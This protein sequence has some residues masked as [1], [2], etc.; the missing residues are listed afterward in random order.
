MRKKVENKIHNHDNY[1][2]TPEFNK[3]TAKSFAKKSNIYI[4]IYIYINYFLPI[5]IHFA[6]FINHLK[7]IMSHS[8]EKLCLSQYPH[9]L[10]IAL[11]SYD[12]FFYPWPYILNIWPCSSVLLFSVLST[13]YSVINSGKYVLSLGKF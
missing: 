7:T 2:T 5:I 12:F 11:C 10:Y 9:K 3:L 4:Y 8:V 13:A 1:I 6:Q